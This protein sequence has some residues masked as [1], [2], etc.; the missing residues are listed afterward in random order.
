MNQL[1]FIKK[2][3]LST[4]FF[5]FLFTIN[6]FAR[7]TFNQEFGQDNCI[8]LG[9]PAISIGD[10]Q[11]TSCKKDSPMT[12]CVSEKT[13]SEDSGYKKL[14]ELSKTIKAGQLDNFVTYLSQPISGENLIYKM[15]ECFPTNNHGKIEWSC[16][17]SLACQCKGQKGNPYAETPEAKFNRTCQLIQFI[18][19]DSGQNLAKIYMSMIYKWVASIIGVI[20]VIYIIING[21]IIS[22]A[23]NDSGQVATAKENITQSLTALVLLM[24]VSIL[25]Y[26]INPN[27]FSANTE[28]Q[29]TEQT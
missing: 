18:I 19:A 7:S 25:L 22:T 21:I 3:L 14:L 16:N 17:S 12:S 28:T 13:I 20:A 1:N 11:Y 9:E 24:V 5:V 15:K 8:D 4:L 26:A 23:Q 6:T 29:T 10:D 2:Y 27:F